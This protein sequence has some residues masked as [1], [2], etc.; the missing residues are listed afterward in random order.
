MNNDTIMID[1][2]QTRC[3]WD[4]SIDDE[5][6]GFFSTLSGVSL[7]LNTFSNKLTRETEPTVYPF[8]GAASSEEGK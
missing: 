8:S 7:F 6:V 1:A 4:L 5:Y 3:G 2:V